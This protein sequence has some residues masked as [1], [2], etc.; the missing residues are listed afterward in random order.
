MEE[1]EEIEK[2]LKRQ[3]AATMFGLRRTEEMSNKIYQMQKEMEDIDRKYMK[4]INLYKEAYEREKEV[5]ASSGE[6]DVDD[7][8]DENEDLRLELEE[9]KLK[10]EEDEAIHENELSIYKEKLGEERLLDVEKLMMKVKGLEDSIEEIKLE[11]QREIEELQ[12]S[13]SENV[14]NL[15]SEHKKELQSLKKETQTSSDVTRTKSSR[16]EEEHKE[17][18][19]TLEFKIEELESLL[20]VK[21]RR[22]KEEVR[23]LKERL[24]E[25]MQRHSQDV[26]NYETKLRE[27]G[28][29]SRRPSISSGPGA[30]EYFRKQLSEVRSEN[31]SLKDELETLKSELVTLRSSKGGGSTS[32]RSTGSTDK[33]SKGEYLRR[34]MMQEEM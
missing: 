2:N 16:A 8:R 32:T 18:I 23:S 31:R 28:D 15:N 33:P 34:A 13:H 30:S 22:H 4:E 29:M 24:D 11:H 12:E 1:K 20:E 19:R 21:K 27:C 3:E 6:E 10:M 26:R 14:K 5:K 9:L 17:K 25:E 7:L